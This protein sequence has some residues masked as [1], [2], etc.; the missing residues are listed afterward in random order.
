MRLTKS[1]KEAFVRA[2][3]DDVPMVDYDEHRHSALLC[4]RVFAE[5]CST[6]KTAKERLPEFEKYLP[7]ERGTTG[8]I[9]LPVANTV[10]D[11][12]N[13]GWPKGAQACAS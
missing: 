4:Q 1:D 9:N 2:V 3:M 10:A 11:L 5:T 6:L 13:A 12:I 8:T 7:T